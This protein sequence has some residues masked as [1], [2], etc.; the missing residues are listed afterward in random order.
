MYFYLLCSKDEALDAF[1]NFKAKVENQYG[2]HIKIVR[3]DRGGE[4]YGKYTENGQAPNSFA[5][6]FQEK[7]IITQYICLIVRIIMVW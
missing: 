6:F 3:S 5:K 7:G 2:K 1:K 4:Y